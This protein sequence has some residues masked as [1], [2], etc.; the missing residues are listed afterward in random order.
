MSQPKEARSRWET[1]R[2][3]TLCDRCNADYVFEPARDGELEGFRPC[4]ALDGED[5]TPVRFRKLLAKDGVQC[6]VRP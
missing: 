3:E 5:L 2:W 6:E 1:G 4:V